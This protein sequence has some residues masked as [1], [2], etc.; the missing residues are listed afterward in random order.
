MDNIG[1]NEQISAAINNR[2]EEI[3]REVLEETGDE[4]YAHECARDF[5][6]II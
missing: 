2:S 4:H 5:Y 3:Y 1:Y 6:P